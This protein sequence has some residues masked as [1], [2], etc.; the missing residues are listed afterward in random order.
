M[1]CHVLLFL[2][3]SKKFWQHTASTKPTGIYIANLYF[4]PLTMAT[5]ETAG[6]PIKPPWFQTPFIGL[7]PHVDNLPLQIVWQFPLN[8]TR[9]RC[10]TAL[11]L[12]S[13]C[14]VMYQKWILPTALS[15]QPWLIMIPLFTLTNHTK[16]QQWCK[17]LTTT[18]LHFTK[19]RKQKNSHYHSHFQPY[20]TSP[21][22]WHDTQL[23]SQMHP[24]T[25]ATTIE[26][27]TYAVIKCYQLFLKIGND[28]DNQLGL[29]RSHHCRPTTTCHTTIQF[30]QHPTVL[31]KFIQCFPLKRIF[32]Y[33]S[34][35]N[36]T[37]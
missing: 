16:T 20:A 26:S 13:T 35:T 25:A 17:Q 27:P 18:Q 5:L 33:H 14:A 28:M 37:V 1:P 11:V 32:C 30:T 31:V 12:Q 21:L 24:T 34:K 7:Q 29:L 10:K 8:S 2:D 9:Q 4:T 22:P 36:T 23:S 3:S 15:I 19:I 6:R